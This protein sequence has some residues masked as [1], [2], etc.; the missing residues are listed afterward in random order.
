M[1]RG[2]LILLTVLLAMTFI[3][4]MAEQAETAEAPAGE[5]SF[6][7]V[8]ISPET[9]IL[10]FDAQG[11]QVTD[12]KALAEVLDK[13]PDLKEVHLFD[14]DLSNDDMGWLFDRYYPRVFFGFTIKIGPHVIRTD[15][16][17]FSTLHHSG[18]TKEDKRH[19]SAE[20]YPLRMC[21]RLKAL[22][23]GHN[24][25][26]DLNFLHW[27]PDIEVLIISPNYGLKDIS[28]VATLKNLVYLECFNT[29]IS[30]VEALA[31]L[32]KLQDLN[33]TMN[34]HIRDISPLY[35]LPNLKRFWWGGLM[36]TNEQRREMR[37]RHPGC[38]FRAVSDPTSGGWRKGSHF[39]T[40]FSFFR[41]GVYVPFPD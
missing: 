34:R 5:L 29:P 26:T 40:L 9:E 25:L 23:L 22:D 38:V 17:A 30:D 13:L 4:G 12:V 21:T 24:Y 3:P 16:T 15:Q 31:G 36:I 28:A 27:L 11:V 10:D 8:S 1:K 7:G 6:Q 41:T 20:L 33:L 35:D 2:L 18:E 19:T 14:S 39:K 37:S 32:T